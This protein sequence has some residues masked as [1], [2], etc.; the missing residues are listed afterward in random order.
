MHRLVMMVALSVLASG[1]SVQRVHVVTRYQPGEVVVYRA[2]PPMPPEVEPPPAP[3]AGY[4]WVS[5]Y[6]EWSGRWT[7]VD[8]HW[9][10]SRPGYVWT[11]PVAA[12]LPEGRIAYHRG[13][14]RPVGQ[15][16]PPV[17]GEP[18]RVSVSRGAPVARAGQSAR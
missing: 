11:P 7:W 15:A 2:P 13:Y 12:R 9:A 5:G 18:G 16:P 14:W 17:Y 6:W 1:C 3:S 4:V 8:G 10:P